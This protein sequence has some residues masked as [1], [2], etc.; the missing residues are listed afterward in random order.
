MAAPGCGIIFSPS[1]RVDRSQSLRR[2]QSLNSKFKHISNK[3]PITTSYTP[4]NAFSHGHSRTLSDKMRSLHRKKN[5]ND[6]DTSA[7]SATSA[8]SAPAPAPVIKR[9]PNQNAKH[10]D[11]I[12]AAAQKERECKQAQDLARQHNGGMQEVGAGKENLLRDGKFSRPALS[13]MESS[14][15]QIAYDHYL[16]QKFGLEG[17]SRPQP[18][19][20]QRLKA[21]QGPAPEMRP[22]SD[23]ST[24]TADSM[25]V[26]FHID[27][28]D[29]PS[30]KE[31][32]PKI[33]VTIPSSQPSRRPTSSGHLV[34]QMNR[35]RTNGRSRETRMQQPQVSP[36]S[37][38]TRQDGE[39]PAR[40][41]VVS[42]LSAV[43]MPKPRRPFSAFSLEE[44]TNDLPQD[45]SALEKSAS[46][47]SSDDTADHDDRS[48]VYSARSS[49]SS[50]TEDASPEKPKP[51]RKHSIAFSIMSPAAAGVFDGMPLTPKFPHKLR[52]AKSVH[53]LGVNM[54]KPL[55]PEPGMADI[56]PL[57]VSGYARPGS[58]KARRKAP[59]P[60]NISR[61][62]TVDLPSL[63]PSRMSSL[64]S[65]YTPADLDALDEAFTKTSP[66]IHAGFYSHPELSLSQAQ[67]ELE[68]QLHT[69]NEDSTFQ[70][71]APAVH[72]P[73]QISRGPN[74]MVPSRQAPPPPS[75]A[76]P[77]LRSSNG[78]INGSRKRIVK[79]S[80][81]IHVAMQ[82]KADFKKQTGESAIEDVMRK[83]LS[84]MPMRGSSMK[85]ERVLGK[86]P[87]ATTSATMEREPSRESNWS[88]SGS[89][90]NNYDDSSSSP[91][92]M[93]REDSSTPETDVSSI[94]D[95]AFEEVRA[96][97]ELLSPKNDSHYVAKFGERKD[98]D[99]S[100]FNLPLQDQSHESTPE[101]TRPTTSVTE[102]T[103]PCIHVTTDKDT[104]SQ[105]E[106]PI[107]LDAD[108]DGS[109]IVL[110]ERRGRQCD[111]VR[112]RSLGSIA[113]SEI[114]DMYASLPS[115]GLTIR[116]EREYSM[117]EEEAERAISADAAEKVLLRILQNLENLQDLFACATVSRGFYRT[118]KRHELPLMK[119]ALYGM[120]PAAWELREMSP[121]Y[122]GLEG[123]D[124]ASPKLDYSPSLYLQH[125]MRDMY[126]MVALKS[127]ILIH[128]ESFLRADTITALAGGETDRA[129]Q[130]D[131]AFW[132]VWTFCQV[133]G[134]GSNREDDIVAQ[135]DW[136]RGGQL[137]AQQRRNKNAMDLGTDVARTSVLYCSP[138]SFGRGNAGGLSAE[139][140]Y[141]MTEI[142]TCLGVLVRGF[143][144]RRQEAR[145]YG[146]F[147][148]ADVTPGDVEK[149]DA[150][151]GK[152]A[153]CVRCEA[154][155]TSILEEW[156]YH[157]LTLAPPTVL[158]VSAAT[159]P[160]PQTFAHAR[161]RGYTSWTPPPVSRATFLKEAVSRV[162]QEKMAIRHPTSPI[163]SPMKA[164]INDPTSPNT[165]PEMNET[166]AARWR[167]ARHAAEIRAKRS[168]PSFKALPPSEDRPM[169]EFPAVIAAL[170]S[171]TA[172]S[173]PRVTTHHK[174][175]SETDT[176]KSFISALVVP[177]GPQV[178]DPVDVAVE[179]LVAMG[180]ESNKCKKALAETDT[181]NSIDFAAAMEW[182]V[183]ERK[184]DVSGLMHATYRGPI[185]QQDVSE[186]PVD[187]EAKIREAVGLGLGNAVMS[188]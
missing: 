178:K 24:M 31:R 106:V 48:S 44:M 104:D 10:L 15:R 89:P 126:T 136:L 80:P 32:R 8:M 127:M 42:P 55:P 92:S 26:N 47:D 165:P 18:A 153:S 180:F 3:T 123:I 144:G 68:A 99:G 112:A 147:D 95:Y 9:T 115:P 131:D 119:N 56:S 113:M 169:S 125:Y 173:I 63:L 174:T 1:Q 87:R 171:E 187:Q 19:A 98:S 43:E 162:Y 64:R 107:A 117:T 81:T 65:K 40:M 27:S 29:I 141:D 17:N 71:A 12:E 102:P 152:L 50:L 137:A 146:I 122:P 25:E 76:A 4:A 149:E 142:W 73:L 38:T 158:D 7:K 21:A 109:S 166:I 72:D 84:T 53:N 172:R 22:D 145:E 78:S 79:K 5:S 2:S 143:Q 30:A 124:N 121:P 36:P 69:I 139:D 101:R 175:P 138:T 188:A 57:N 156:T 86:P 51:E 23:M 150:V 133:F 61:N 34:N 85:A 60:L 170:D 58:M 33:H 186:S 91:T 37:S 154:E 140:L 93:S 20:V 14:Y 39:A 160:T 41:S 110:L 94:P 179:K 157:L 135:M 54:N 130:I 177:A 13:K 129:S 6:S 176:S 100:L 45:T 168:D 52:G 62:S 11:L 16:S 120:S 105:L 97:L 118:Y 164:T 67:L 114:P 88:S 103:T 155:L 77:S 163:N 132:R 183:R 161:S 167:V 66:A 74:T 181:G 59:S 159:S 134:C 75:T 108:T 111:E 90:H 128:C 35:Q 116:T 148:N 96:R 185:K 151:L 28:K 70:A 82:M 83:R 182:L 46:S 184:R 49:M